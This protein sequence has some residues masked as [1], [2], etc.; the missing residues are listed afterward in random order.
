MC[1]MSTGA[2][3]HKVPT[4]DREVGSGRPPQAPKH[5]Q[6]GGV[7]DCVCVH[8]CELPSRKLAGLCLFHWHS[9]S[10][11]TWR[12]TRSSKQNLHISRKHSCF[13]LLFLL[14]CFLDKVDKLITFWHLDGLH[15]IASFTPWVKIGLRGIKKDGFSLSGATHKYSVVLDISSPCWLVFS[16]SLNT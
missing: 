4:H 13:L 1:R 14:T 3:A 7:C 16:W 12:C 5:D 11:I 9:A 15:I 8:A 2:M 10:R 6:M